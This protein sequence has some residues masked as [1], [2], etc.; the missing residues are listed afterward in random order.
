L[1]ALGVPADRRV[2]S[3][4]DAGLHEVFVRARCLVTDYSSM[5]F[6]AAYAG[7]PTVYF[8][9]DRRRVLSGGHVG[10]AGYFD[11]ERDGFG[12]VSTDVG[13]VISALENVLA[14]RSGIPPPYSARI[15][16]TFP[17]RDGGCCARVVAAIEA[18]DQPRR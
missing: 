13:G 16:S 8:Q 4:D 14:D 15:A 11:Y 2:L 5:A 6:N 10:R 1:P 12:P 3:F 18:M 17:D 7:R 9:F